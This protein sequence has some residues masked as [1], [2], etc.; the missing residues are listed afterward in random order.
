MGRIERGRAYIS[1]AWNHGTGGG[2]SGIG[3]EG[4]VVVVVEVGVAVVVVVVLRTPVYYPAMEW[5]KGAPYFASAFSLL[6]LCNART[7]VSERKIER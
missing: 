4:V 7:G 5:K 6:A 1:E 2:G 3:A